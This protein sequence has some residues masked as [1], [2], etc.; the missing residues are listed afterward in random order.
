[1]MPLRGRRHDR[2]VDAEAEGDVRQ[3]QLHALPE[4]RA[5][6]RRDEWQNDRQPGRH[7]AALRL[8]AILCDE[9]AGVAA[10]IG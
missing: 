5:M 4:Y 7:R 6:S 8:A 3:A 10:E 9:L 2:Q 1:M